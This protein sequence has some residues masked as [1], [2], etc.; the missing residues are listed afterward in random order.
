VAKYKDGIVDKVLSKV[1]IVDLVSKYVTL[2]RTGKNHQGLCPFHSEKT[3]SFVVSQEKQIFHCFGCGTKGNAISFIMSKENLDFLDA[4]EFISDKY[5]IDISDFIIDEG[6]KKEASNMIFY[7]INKMAALYYFRNL[8]TSQ[9]GS[10]YFKSRGL[11]DDTLRRFGLGFSPNDWEGLHSVLKSNF[12]SSDLEKSG[13]FSVTKKDNRLVDRFRNR[14]IFPIIDTRKRV[15][16][17][18]AR[19]LTDEHPKYLNSPETPVFSK[20]NVLF[21]LNQ[22]KDNIEGD[23]LILCEGYMDV[24][25]LFDKGIKNAVATLGTAVTNGHAK[26]LSRYVKKVILFYDSD[27]AG[28]NATLK[29]IEIL[30]GTVQVFV[31]ELDKF[32]DPDDFIK[33]NGKEA[34]KEKIE[35][36]KYFIDYL[37]DEYKNGID[38]TRPD[39]R[40]IYY[41][42]IKPILESLNSSV[43]RQI[44]IEKLSSEIGISQS[45]IDTELQGIKKS[46]I[47]EERVKKTINSRKFERILFNI[48]L[49]KKYEPKYFNE[50]DIEKIFTK[51]YNKNLYE[52][53][54]YVVNNG[55]DINEEVISKFSMEEIELLSEVS[56]SKDYIKV[57]SIR[58]FKHLLVQLLEQQA[59]VVIESLKT[60]LKNE[61]SEINS[62]EE[63]E[64][65]KSEHNIR[66]NKIKLEITNVKKELLGDRRENIE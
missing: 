37:F 55:V 10:N 59:A 13:V 54:I 58:H 36:S 9:D 48:L 47:V 51:L 15:I 22:A 61:L 32:K 33:S 26:I 18:G 5:S 29:A 53:I 12:S 11:S 45:V 14:V 60:K 1:D 49:V 27:E 4:L 28:K 24:I 21:N 38:F 25:S 56:Q 17:F 44:Y 40:Y 35:N 41:E 64:R 8:K 46:N 50:V 57:E 7:E 42:K 19:T 66:E 39:D 65:I 20:G 62:Y 52:F 31:G 2:K 16:G 43:Q 63:K 23:Y 6:Y 34:F 30:K 3:P